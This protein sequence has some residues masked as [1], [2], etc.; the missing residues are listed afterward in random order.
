MVV[1]FPALTLCFSTE[2]L[3]FKGPAFTL[4]LTTTDAL[5]AA[6]DDHSVVMQEFMC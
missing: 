2:I 3:F 4:L 5:T 6:A 1:S